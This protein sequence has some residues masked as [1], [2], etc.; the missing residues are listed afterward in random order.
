M[1]RVS[2]ESYRSNP[3]QTMPITAGSGF[4]NDVRA[5]YVFPNSGWQ[6]YVGVTNVFD[7]DPPVN[8]FGTTFGSA[9]YDAIGRAYYAGFNYN[10]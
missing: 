1:L 7:R 6:A 4:F 8:L 2:N 10:F 9:L 5:S 3:K